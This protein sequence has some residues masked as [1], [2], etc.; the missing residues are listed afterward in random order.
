MIDLEG[1]SG[2]TG[3]KPERSDMATKVKLGLIVGVSEDVEG[4]LA[5][6]VESVVHG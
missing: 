4:E 2:T 6:M 5:K 1:G 3:G